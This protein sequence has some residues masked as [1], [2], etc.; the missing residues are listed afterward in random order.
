MNLLV[1]LKNAKC[2][3]IPEQ[4]VAVFTGSSE[5]VGPALTISYSGT[6]DR[7]LTRS[8]T[9]K[10]TACVLQPEQVPSIRVST[11]G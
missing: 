9:S 6:G 8:W 11:D 3:Q 4:L 2:T 5:L 7:C 10:L 1:A